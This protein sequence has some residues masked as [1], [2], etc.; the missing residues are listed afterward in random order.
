MKKTARKNRGRNG[1]FTLVELMTVISIIAFLSSVSIS[2]LQAAKSK[3]Q[4]SKVTQEIRQYQN[5]FSLYY[6][7]NGSFPMPKDGR[8][9]PIVSDQTSSGYVCLGPVNSSCTIA[10]D[11]YLG[12]RALNDSLSPYFKTTPAINGEPVVTNGITYQG[13]YYECTEIS[14]SGSNA[15]CKEAKIYWAQK[16]SSCGI[17]FASATSISDTHNGSLVCLASADGSKQASETQGMSAVQVQNEVED[18]QSTSFG[19]GY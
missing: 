12:N 19:Y 3:A 15:V 5:A 17:G 13:A 1:G 9:N 16:G 7:Q 11:D 10:D 8:N 14:G 18:E 6:S 2:G 4:E